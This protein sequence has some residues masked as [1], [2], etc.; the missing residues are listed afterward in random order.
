MHRH[1][2]LLEVL[3][4]QNLKYSDEELKISRSVRVKIEIRA[5]MQKKTVNST[6]M[7]YGSSCRVEDLTSGIPR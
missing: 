3:I 2:I 6:V 7:G 4:K 5:E 1:C